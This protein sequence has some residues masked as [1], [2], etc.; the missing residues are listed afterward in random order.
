[1]TNN[2]DNILHRPWFPYAVYLI[3]CVVA[4]LFTV[5][6]WGWTYWDFGDGNYMYIA[7]RVREGLVLY[8]DILAPQPPLHTLSGVVAQSMGAMVGISELT[9]TRIF[10]LLVR[11][12][13]GLMILM[14]GLRYFRCPLRA[15][16]GAAVYLALPIGFWWSICYQSENLEIVFLVAALYCILK[17]E[18]R[19]AL[20]AGVFSALATHCNMTGLPFFMANLIFLCFRKI[21]LA[22]WYAGSFFVVY[23]G[24]AVA[25]NI[26]TSGYFISNVLLNQVGTFPRTDILSSS[27][28]PPNSFLGYVIDKVPREALKVLEIQGIIIMAAAVGVAAALLAAPRNRENR[29]EWL[30]TEFLAW[31]F[32][33]GLLSICFT[34][35]GGT[36]NYIFVL[37]EPM[38]ALFAGS[39]FVLLFRTFLPRTKEDWKSLSIRDTRVFLKVTM[40]V[41]VLVIAWIP[42]MRNIGYTLTQAQSELPEEQ[43]M[44][45]RGII[46]EYA[47]PGDKILAPPFYAFLTDTVIAGELAENYIW[48]IKWMNE[49]FDEATYGIPT[50]EAVEKFE[51]IAEMLNRR[52]VAIVL[53][54]MAQTGRVDVIQQALQEHYKLAENRPLRTRNTTLEVLIPADRR[55]THWRLSE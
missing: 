42:S 21:H 13:G 14:L 35:K 8:R 3:F 7:R 19:G 52:E 27:P 29:D 25:A 22:P 26:W 28:N 41:L 23:T 40:P 11:L 31:N 20:I 55:I 10:T 54:D 48:Q 45:I 17:W 9:S 1:M 50:D 36:V 43:V 32:I 4:A 39:A 38:V 18:A 44:L 24:G 33:A 53:L 34:A 37:G 46:Q 5:P 49:R 15:L 16:A 2:A 47:E 12:T 51:E 6:L 30:R